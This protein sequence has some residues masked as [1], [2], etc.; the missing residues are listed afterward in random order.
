MGHMLA[1]LRG[2]KL[3]VLREILARDAPEH[4][5]HGL[6]L[7]HLWQNADDPNEV[8]FLFRVRDLDHARAYVDGLHAEARRQDPQANL[9]EMTFLT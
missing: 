6:V 2:V 3:D 8:L 5:T 4:A 1:R 9:P 7:E